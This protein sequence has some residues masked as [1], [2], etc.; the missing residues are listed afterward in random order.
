MVRRLLSAKREGTHPDYERDTFDRLL[1]ERFRIERRE[2]LG[3]GTRAL[4]LA[5]PRE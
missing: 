4:Y 3:S 5:L 1:A 2:P